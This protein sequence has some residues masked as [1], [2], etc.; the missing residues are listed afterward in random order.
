MKHASN[1]SRLFLAAAVLCLAACGSDTPSPAGGE[2][3]EA[4]ATPDPRAEIA[5]GLV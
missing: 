1:L 5:K 2:K 4:T 3:S